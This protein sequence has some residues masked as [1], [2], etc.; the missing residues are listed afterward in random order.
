[1]PSK[2]QI[3][4]NLNP[5]Q[6]EAV[7]Y[8][9][10]SLLVHAGAGSGKTRILTHRIAYLIHQGVA[11]FQIM[12]VT[13]TNKAANEM[14]N[15]VRKL[16]GKEVWIQTF[17]ST[18]LKILKM[19]AGQEGIP[20]EFNIYD[21]QDQIVLI[22]ECMKELR[23]N[24]KQTN[25]KSVREAI[26][27]AKDQLKLPMDIELESSDYYETITAKIYKKYQEKMEQFKAFDFGDLIM[28]CVKFLESNEQARKHYQ[29]RFTHVL[30][31]EYQD[32]NKAQYELVK[33][34]TG[35]EGYITVVGD[36]DQSIY[37]WRG[38]DIRNILE[39]EKD[40]LDSHAI[41]LEQN[42]RST[43]NILKAAN[44]V[45][46]RNANRKPKA[47]WSDREDGNLINIY[48]AADEREE[49]LFIVNQIKH[50]KSKGYSLKDMVVFYR[51]HAQSRV[52]EDSLRRQNIPYVIVGGVRFYDRK[53]I[54]DLI[55]Y[56][57][58]LVN[59]EDEVSLK[60]IINNPTRGIGKKTLDIVNET[61]NQLG[62]SFYEALLRAHSIP[63]LT[64]KAK[65]SIALFSQ[66]ME[67]FKADRKG[68]S[69]EELIRRVLDQSGY[70]LQ[71]QKEGTIESKS[72]IENIQEFITVVQEYEEN[73][74]S[75]SETFGLEDFLESISLETNLDQWS[76]S[77][78]CLTM[79]TLH[80]AKG[81]EFPIVFMV[82]LEE[83]V[84]PHVN[85]YGDNR[86]GIEEER[87]LCYVGLTRAMEHLHLSYASSRRMYGFTA[88]N[89]PSRFLSEIPSELYEY[90]PRI[91]SYGDD[92][93]KPRNKVQKDD[94]DY[95]D[96]D[97][98]LDEIKKQDQYD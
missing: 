18:C 31:D 54:K 83:E 19:E 62:L 1:M 7:V 87:R 27:R 70:L 68:L 37:A 32:T 40:Y 46:A 17:H 79:M 74:D 57:K 6:K 97:I 93:F 71:L 22:K 85:S 3:L 94:T 29:N 42:Y 9:G 48:E 59:S 58:V 23:I 20:S 72:R 36:P 8:E 21:D 34:L 67:R 11:P 43:N 73:H 10:K 64:P 95:F 69:I 55:A 76:E 66:M 53:E 41:K 51:V 2:E 61:K 84:F 39:F 65:K 4:E 96:L 78:D 15:R 98:D 13:F 33:I 44:N 90:I 89:L 47:L 60:R 16:V 38:A 86:N 28:K 26:N 75:K 52:I 49:S 50:Y 63:T 92:E 35:P 82:G 14:R 30:I 24:D 5:S 81:L 25:P 91:F 12:G 88:Q 80:T 45:I 56:L 77:D